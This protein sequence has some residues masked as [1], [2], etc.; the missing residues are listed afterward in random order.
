MNFLNNA[1]KSVMDDQRRFQD[2]RKAQRQMNRQEG[3]DERQNYKPGLQPAYN[4]NAAIGKNQMVLESK[5]PN[6]RG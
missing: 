4:L 2:R 3:V 6:K 1:T 5:L